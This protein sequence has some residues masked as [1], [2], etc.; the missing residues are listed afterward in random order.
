MA[1]QQAAAAIED[2]RAGG[3]TG[4]HEAVMAAL[5]RFARGASHH[6]DHRQV[7]IVLSD[8]EDTSSLPTFDDVLDMARRS[9]VLV[10]TVS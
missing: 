6:T 10:Y 2:I 8:G 4:L 7:L 9:R 1:Q 5:G 3:R